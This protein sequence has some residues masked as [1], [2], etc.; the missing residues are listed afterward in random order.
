M[1][2]EDLTIEQYE[3]MA[4]EG[5]LKPLFKTVRGKL[6]GRARKE[7]LLSEEDSIVLYKEQL[8]Q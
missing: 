2:G 4:E 5:R 1:D 6:T 7:R 3:K 8:C